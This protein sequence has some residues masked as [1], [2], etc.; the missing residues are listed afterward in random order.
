MAYA[1]MWVMLPMLDGMRFVTM[2]LLAT[3]SLGA[4]AA[5]LRLAHCGQ[6]PGVLASGVRSQLWAAAA[7][8][9]CCAHSLAPP[10]PS[11]PLPSPP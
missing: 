10:L 7:G 6:F 3:V 11:P 1:C 5:L 2:A 9:F 8:G 4:C